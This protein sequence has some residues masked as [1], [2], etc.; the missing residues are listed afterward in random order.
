MA[1][2]TV[3]ILIT[4]YNQEKYVDQAIQS[5]FSQNGDFCLRIL[6][7]DD[8]S[9]DNTPIILEKWKQQYPDK[10]LV[11]TMTRTDYD[12]VPGGFRAARNRLNL[13]SKVNADYFIFLDGDD[14]FVDENKLQK[15]IS[16]LEDVRNKDCIAC[17]HDI[18]AIYKSGERRPYTKVRKYEESYTLKK[19]WPNTYLHTDTILFRRE[20]ISAVPVNL[21]ED[22]F[23]DNGITF[24]FLHKGKIYYLPEA[25]AV[26]RQTDG[27]IW[28]GEKKTVSMIR[29]MM[30]YDFVL[31]YDPSLKY[32]TR[33][34]YWEIWKTLYAMKGNI[35][36]TERLDPYVE[37][38]RKQNY[39]YTLLWINRGQLGA[40][41]YA[42]L[43][44]EFFAIVLCRT[45]FKTQQ[46]V[47]TIFHRD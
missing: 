34:R 37:E 45:I 22:V 28:T 6:I 1:G 24:L 8:G 23:N 43:Y 9:N 10:I 26:Y 18:D 38:A 41:E 46:K 2:V 7:G 15:Q 3:D 19:Y 4:F 36:L 21:P 32:E 33:V 16:V 30:F 47:N 25:M 42:V 5:V 27:G 39:K 17:G 35:S 31:K 20:A 12:H 44:K 40:I 14:Y 11:F 29:E 13:L